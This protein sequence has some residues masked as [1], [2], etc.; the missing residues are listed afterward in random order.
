VESCVLA[1]FEESSGYNV[2]FRLEIQPS[3]GV[4]FICV[5]WCEF[6]NT[7]CYFTLSIGLA[8][9]LSA[10]NNRDNYPPYQ[11]FPGSREYP[12]QLSWLTWSVHTLSSSKLP[13]ARTSTSPQGTAF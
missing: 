4:L 11:L 12:L 6:V 3:L 10:D 7:R 8:F 1:R 2:K 9:L 13:N 5:D